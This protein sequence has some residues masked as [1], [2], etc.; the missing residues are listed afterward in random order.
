VLLRFPSPQ[1]LIAALALASSPDCAVNGDSLQ[2]RLLS[3]LNVLYVLGAVLAVILL[4]VLAFAVRAWYATR[5]SKD[6]PPESPKSKKASR[7]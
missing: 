5:N 6:I 3:F 1:T 2:C 4:V 7:T